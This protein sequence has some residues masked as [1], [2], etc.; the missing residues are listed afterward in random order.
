[1]K[2]ALNV[3]VLMREHGPDLWDKLERAGFPPTAMDDDRVY[4]Q[5]D[6][7]VDG[8][9]VAQAEAAV[10]RA[11]LAQGTPVKAFCYGSLPKPAARMIVRRKKSLRLDGRMLGSDPMTDD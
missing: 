10:E 3:G 11:M 6:V 8:A 5:V 7:E 9:L 1:M 4:V 2:V